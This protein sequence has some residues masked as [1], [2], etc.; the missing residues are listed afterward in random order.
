[1]IIIN[2]L[3]WLLTVREELVDALLE[4]GH[5]VSVIGTFDGGEKKLIRK[6]CHCHHVEVQRRKTNVISDAGILIHSVRKIREIRPDAVLTF[7]VKANIFG[8]L[9]ARMLRVPRIVT[10][11]GVGTGFQGKGLL[12][13]MLTFLYQK[14][15]LNADCVFFQNEANMLFMKEK[16]ILSK[17]RNVRLIKGSGVNL[18]KHAFKEYPAETDGI[19]F[20][21]IGRIMKEKGVDELLEAFRIIHSEFPQT[22]LDIL[23]FVDDECYE[24][25]LIS[26]VQSGVSYHGEVQDVR[27]YLANSHCVVLPSYHEGMANVLLEAAAT[28]RPVIASRIPGCVETFDEGLSGI[29][30]DSR[31]A[32]GLAEAMKAFLNIPAKTRADMGKRGRTKVEREFDRKKV[33]AEYIGEIEQISR[34]AKQYE[35]SV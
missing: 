5:T 6:G 29:G 16:G 4:E 20:L 32:A 34:S 19:R 30:C 21:F 31:S 33:I 35:K 8:A 27:P 9:A 18:E 10:I 25:V 22:S 26:D 23:G 11:T 13:R 15:L 7:S 1:M 14:S 3:K 17:A 24:G 12:P 2:S 28:G